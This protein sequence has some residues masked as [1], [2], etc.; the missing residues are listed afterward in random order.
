MLEDKNSFIV[1]FPFEFD[2]FY[3]ELNP[4]VVLLQI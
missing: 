3:V 1:N 2:I 4:A